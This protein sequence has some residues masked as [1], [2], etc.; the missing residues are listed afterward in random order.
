MPPGL[1]PPTAVLLPEI[2]HTR[3]TGGQKAVTSLTIG[4]KG[5]NRW[6]IV[7]IVFKL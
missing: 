3:V 5:A 6:R 1:W 7:S 4:A 2:L